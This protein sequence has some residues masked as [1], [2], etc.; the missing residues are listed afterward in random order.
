MRV[1]IKKGFRTHHADLS[2]ANL[3]IKCMLL[4]LQIQNDSKVCLIHIIYLLKSL[5]TTVQVCI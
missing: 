4:T 3:I 1:K 5:Q 2:E